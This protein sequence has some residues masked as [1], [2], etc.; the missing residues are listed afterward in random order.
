MPSPRSQKTILRFL[1]VVFGG[2]GIVALLPFFLLGLLAILVFDG[3]PLFFSQQRVGKDYSVLTVTKIRT[4]RVGSEGLHE[5]FAEK[6]QSAT[7]SVFVE[8]QYD[9]RITKTGRFLRSSGIDEY[10]QLVAVML[11]QMSLVGP[12]PCLPSELGQIPISLHARFTVKAG[13]SGE[14]QIRKADFPGSDSAWEIDARFADN[15]S[16][17][18]YLKV[19]FLTPVAMA[20][21]VAR[22]LR[23]NH[24]FLPGQDK[25]R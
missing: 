1:D 2:I 4:M 8:D 6:A 10:P 15:L 19:L 3:R 9:N 21:G 11:G 20:R 24:D 12:R 23:K 5:E 16:V 17:R 18:S 13:L 25:S 7:G 22:A 14:W